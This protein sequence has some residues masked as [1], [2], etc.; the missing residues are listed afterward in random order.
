MMRHIRGMTTNTVA[1]LSRVRRHFAKFLAA[2]RLD[3]AEKVLDRAREAAVD[4][5]V[6]A[7]LRRTLAGARRWPRAV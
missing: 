7:S 3:E 1:H 4:P 6:V 5:Q 2:G